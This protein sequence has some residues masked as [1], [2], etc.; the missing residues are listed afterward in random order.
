MTAQ[1][2][3]IDPILPESYP[4][5]QPFA[6]SPPAMPE[7][8][9]ATAL[10][11]PFSPPQEGNAQPAVPF[12]QLCIANLSYVAGQYF[13]AQIAGTQYG[14]WWFIMSPQEGTQLSL[15]M[16]ATW[17]PVDMGWQLPV[18]GWFGEPLP[19]P[20]P[21][22]SCA[23]TSPLNWMLA[24]NAEWWKLPVTTP[25]S[26]PQATVYGA[27]WMWFDAQSRNPVRMMYGQGPP[28]PIKGDPTQLP[29]LQMYSFT[30]FPSFSASA[31]PTPPSWTEPTIAG[32]QVGNPGG[33]S[34]FVFNS[35]FGMTAFTTPVNEAYNPL[36]TRVLY[37]WK[38]D[39]E[40]TVATDRAQSTLMMFDTTNPEDPKVSQEALLMGRVPQGMPSPP[41]SDTSFLINNYPESP[42]SCIGPAQQFDF[43]QEA[44][45]WISVPGVQAT[46]TAT[47]TNNAV[48]CPGNTILI[49]SV[50]FPPAE[51]NY[52]DSTYLWT[53][54]SPLSPDGTL[55]RPVTF[56]Q[57]QSGINLGTSL[58]LADYFTFEI[59]SQPIDPDN[60]TV[61]SACALAEAQPQPTA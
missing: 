14:T 36:P 27:T 9:S 54:Y 35:N 12:Y 30:Y 26:P 38:P 58:A 57:S 46:I 56:M 59:F 21:L 11:Q 16:G 17:M 8:W 48:L 44:P 24:Q 7:Q 4:D 25:S 3:N 37:V 5:L 34:N 31:S 32:F 39:A 18:N 53:W 13:S 1:P 43:P 15:D 60:F 51:P 40:Y 10:L 20:A 42:Q 47:I 29:L 61:P 41:N 28:S 19:A 45:D 33:Y 55:S 22:P 2:V 52:P 6:G 50:L 49:Y 23:G